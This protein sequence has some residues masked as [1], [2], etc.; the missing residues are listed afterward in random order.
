ME[1]EGGGGLSQAILGPG[2]EGCVTKEEEEI[3]KDGGG[4]LKTVNREVGKR[5]K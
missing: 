4:G 3:K 1:V 5:K 2:A